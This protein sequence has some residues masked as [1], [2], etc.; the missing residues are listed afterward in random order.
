M[1]ATCGVWVLL[2]IFF[3]RHVGSIMIVRFSYPTYLFKGKKEQPKKNGYI[4][5]K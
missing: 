5:E 2:S 3:I 1:S 4:I